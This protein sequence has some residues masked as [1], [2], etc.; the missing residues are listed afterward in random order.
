[1]GGWLLAVNANS[2]H[3]EEAMK[4]VK[5]FTSAESQLWAALNANR[6]PARSD[7]Y[8]APELQRGRG[9]HQARR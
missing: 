3:K 5:K 7:V 8:G 1:M 2:E 9:A 6:A 4:L